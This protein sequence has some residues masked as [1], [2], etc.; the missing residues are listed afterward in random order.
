MQAE[1]KKNPS[2]DT[3]SSSSTAPELT[4]AAAGTKFTIVCVVTT[5]ACL[6]GRMASMWSRRRRLTV[7]MPGR[8]RPVHEISLKKRTNHRTLPADSLL[9]QSTRSWKVRWTASR[10]QGALAPDGDRLRWR[11]DPAAALARVLVGRQVAVVDAEL[12]LRPWRYPVPAWVGST[13]GRPGV[14]EGPVGVGELGRVDREAVR[15]GDDE[16]LDDGAAGGVALGAH[17]R[18]TGAL[19]CRVPGQVARARAVGG[20]EYRLGGSDALQR[21]EPGGAPVD[22]AAGPVCLVADRRAGG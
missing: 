9:T 8:L 14:G 18:D 20:L 10:R 3:C 17:H 1:R 16:P 2:L 7:V 12:V 4:L 11:V 19:G 21:V 6:I 15:P 13:G 22:R 5:P